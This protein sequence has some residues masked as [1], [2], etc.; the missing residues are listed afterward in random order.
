MGAIFP[1]FIMADTIYSISIDLWK[2]R[3]PNLGGGVN[4]WKF[5]SILSF[6]KI[7]SHFSTV[8]NA[9][10]PFLSTLGKVETQTLRGSVIG[11]FALWQFSTKWEPFFTFCSM[12]IFCKMGAVLPFFH[13]GQ[14]KISIG[15]VYCHHTT[16][17]LVQFSTFKFDEVSVLKTFMYRH[18]CMMTFL[19]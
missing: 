17:T 11:N 9:N 16:S 12:M 10:F 2:S 7:G 4:N 1:F 19:H 13:N 14:C 8:A 5:C 18:S 15:S 3:D 6:C